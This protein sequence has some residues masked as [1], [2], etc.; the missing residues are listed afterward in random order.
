MFLI[1]FSLN[2]TQPEFTLMISDI[3]NQARASKRYWMNFPANT[4]KFQMGQRNK[5]WTRRNYSYPVKKKKNDKEKE[6][7]MTIIPTNLWENILRRWNGC[8]I[9]E[10]PTLIKSI[11]WS[12]S[13]QSFPADV[14]FHTLLN[15]NQIFN[16]IVNFQKDTRTDYTVRFQGLSGSAHRRSKRTPVGIYLHEAHYHGECEFASSKKYRK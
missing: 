12:D 14:I 3:N 9:M 13:I 15:N 4:M 10:K 1:Y 16:D 11:T 6:H 7:S 2:N 5:I 8:K